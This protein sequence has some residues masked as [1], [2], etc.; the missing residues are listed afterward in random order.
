MIMKKNTYLL[1][2]TNSLG[3]FPKVA[4]I[5]IIMISTVISNIQAQSVAGTTWDLGTTYSASGSAGYKNWG[6][7]GVITLTDTTSAPGNTC[8]ASSV[9]ETSGYDPTT[10]FSMCFKAF[11][12]CPGNDVIGSSS[13]PPASYYTDLNGDGMAFSFWKNN[14]TFTPN[15]GNNACGGGLGYDGALNGSGDGDNK[16]ISIEFD[17]YSS[18]GLN[19]SPAVDGYYGGGA[20]GSGL[21]T[22]EISIHVDQQSNDLGLINTPPTGSTVN[23]GNL[24]D[25]KEHAVCITYSASTHILTVSIDGSVAGNGFLSYDLG[26]TYNFNTYFGGKTLNYTWSGGEYGANNF[27]TIAPAGAPIFGTFGKNPC[28]NVVM[29]VSLIDFSGEMVNEAV[30]LNWATA[31]ETN[32]A[33]FVIERST[34]SYDWETIGEVTG[35]GNSISIHEYNFIDYNPVGGTVYYRL[36]QVDVNGSFAYSN[37]INVKTASLQASVSIIPNPFEDVLT[38]QSNLK[39]NLDI[40]IHDILGQLVYHTNQKSDNGT[41]RIQPNNV[42]SGTYIITIQTDTFV[43]QQKIIR[44]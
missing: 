30:L 18:L 34:N 29:P 25:G 23:A 24:E 44:R 4:F 41:L 20:P 32:N 27:Q 40:S 8:R 6:A 11:F 22:D 13:S 43:K 1:K 21:I 28:T 35:A 42:T 7:N 10:D 2:I 12:G 16:M 31:N 17:T 5:V 3:W 15:A 36:R 38:I 39:E 26:A 37:I 19:S 9:T 33:K 14:S